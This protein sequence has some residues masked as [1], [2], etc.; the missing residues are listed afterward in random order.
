MRN[1]RFQVFRMAPK[2]V[3]SSIKW[4]CGFS[5]F[6]ALQKA[7]LSSPWVFSVGLRL[8][9]PSYYYLRFPFEGRE[10]ILWRRLSKESFSQQNKLILVLNRA[11]WLTEQAL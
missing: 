5:A 2:R 4:I 7:Y 11:S 9:F 6:W 3:H 10:R 1:I 8:A